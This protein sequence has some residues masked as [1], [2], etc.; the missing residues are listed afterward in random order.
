[1]INNLY[2]F[3]STHSK[4]NPHL[5]ASFKD[6]LNKSDSDLVRRIQLKIIQG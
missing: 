2:E 6:F 4:E 1:M 3:Q 5:N